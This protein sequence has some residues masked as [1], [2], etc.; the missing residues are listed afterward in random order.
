MKTEANVYVLEL[1][2]KKQSDYSRIIVH[3]NKSHYYPEIM[4]YYDRGDNKVKVASYTF[5]QIGKYWNASEIEITDLKKNHITKMQMSDVK[6]DTGLT[7]D[8]F[9]VRKLRQ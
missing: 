4:E 2:P 3:I 6:Y 7:D 8:E 5:R 9:T 1:K